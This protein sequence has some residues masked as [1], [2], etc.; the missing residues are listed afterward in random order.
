MAPPLQICFPSM[1]SLILLTILSTIAVYRITAILSVPCVKDGKVVEIR[2]YGVPGE[3]PLFIKH[4]R[5]KNSEAK[6]IKH[7]GLYPQFQ[8]LK[9]GGSLLAMVSGDRSLISPET[10][11]T[12]RKS[13][14]GHLLVISGQQLAL[15]AMI[16]LWLF[17]PIERRFPFFAARYELLR[18]NG[19][20][21]LPLIWGY[22]FWTGSD[23]A[24]IRSGM[25][26]TVFFLYKAL[27]LRFALWQWFALTI[28]LIVCVFPA[29]VVDPGFHLSLFAVFGIILA[30]KNFPSKNI[31]MKWYITTVGAVLGV[32]PI[33]AF[34]FGEFAFFGWL[35][36]L[37]AAPLIVFI[38][39]AVS[40]ATFLITL[41][42][43]LIPGIVLTI[44]DWLISIFTTLILDPIADHRIAMISVPVNGLLSLSIF[45]ITIV[46]SYRLIV[47]RRFRALLLAIFAGLLILCALPKLFWI[48]TKKPGTLQWT[49]ISVGQG[50]SLLFRFPTGESML[51]DGGGHFD[52]S[53]DPGESLVIPTLNNLGVGKIDLLVVSHPDL[54]HLKGLFAVLRRK[55]IKRIW[56]NEFFESSRYL[57]GFLDEAH[58]RNITVVINPSGKF[59]Y[60]KAGV[61]VIKGLERYDSTNNRSMVLK[62]SYGKHS[63]L[64][65]GDIE[66]GR[67]KAILQS[68]ADIDVNI[69]KIP[70]HGSKTSSIKEFLYATSPGL[71]I[72]SAGYKNRYNHPD[73]SVTERLKRQ[74]IP[75]LL[76]ATHGSIQVETDGEL[77]EVRCFD[78]YKR[79][80]THCL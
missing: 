39:P 43:N 41:H 42:I 79:R 74:K 46:V 2:P 45:L 17:V 57:K 72:I 68:D 52:N 71:G 29:V 7:K 23:G 56:I 12:W 48:L 22:V 60:G 65:T 3:M 25:M 66:R 32:L 31:V 47:R 49:T 80:W 36:S 1:R 58:R 73:P 28:L 78:G 50:E 64:L 70:H 20:I 76:T 69:L 21:I 6:K 63:F 15:L 44:S 34:Y 13:G 67:E 77:L 27:Y 55:D 5:C 4:L 26:L 51:I 40:V 53:F 35:S 11:E 59:T 54:D 18:W 75:Y 37:I 38:L 30:N 16:M 33:C 14:V 61:E 8:R 10:W 9:N 24:T 62:I 19:I